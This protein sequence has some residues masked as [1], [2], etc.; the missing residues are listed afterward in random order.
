MNVELK[1][2]H[3]DRMVADQ[4][5]IFRRLRLQ[6]FRNSS[7]LVWD[8]SRIRVI[9][10][11]LCSLVVWASIFAGAMF[12]FRLIAD[13]Q[14]FFAGGIVQLLFETLFFTLGFM[15]FF[16]TGLVIYASLFT[17]SETKF[18]LTT[19][20]R[21]DHIFAMKFQSGILFSSWAFLVLG[22][23][24]LISYG[25]VFSVPWYFYALLPAFFFGYVLIPGA[26]GGIFSLIFV[27][28]FPQ[29]RKTVLV[30]SGVL[31]VGL[32]L[33]WIGR[34]LMTAKANSMKNDSLQ[35]LFD[36]FTLA[37]S[38]FSPSHW[39]ASGIILMA[40]GEATAALYPLALIWANGLFLFL[41]AAYMA[42]KLY[43]R[44][45]NLLAT[46]GDLRKRYGTHFLDRWVHR[47][48]FFLD[49]Q[50]RLLIVKDFRTFRREPA[51]I[52]QLAIFVILLMICIVN[53]RSFF[54]ADIPRGYQF[55]LSLMLIV[56]TLLLITAFLGRFVYPLMSLEGKKFWI[57]GLLP[58]DRKKLL[59]GKFYFA[60]LGTGLFGI[61]LT[62]ISDLVLKM[63]WNAI[64]IHLLSMLAIVSGLC[65]ISVGISATLP[66]FRETD[67]S[68]IVLG[69]GGTMNMIAGLVFLLS[70]V[71]LMLV[72]FHFKAAW[73]PVELTPSVHIGAYLGILT[74]LVVAGFATWMPMR[75]GIRHL[76]RME[77]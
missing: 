66:N 1:L 77:F 38:S 76:D 48:A 20:A 21:A 9:T 33:L 18:L 22:G 56:A 11:I 75:S 72:P 43:R 62:I 71:G 74:G 39:I 35:D 34:L 15:L 3:S 27:N 8:N 37:S 28:V 68:R 24:I 53:T 67:P 65:G 2:D 40:R 64:W 7:N 69:F 12:V 54:R 47:L 30:I 5:Q 41:V 61:G 25:V 6:Q 59:W 29:R 4:G 14:I 46:G 70:V 57:L 51:Q 32:G 60:F 63:P 16:S 58:L 52:G 42:K 55:A 73:T 23:P 26:L 10:A 36:F 45:Y 13:G 17:S 19:P 44:G 50:I 49:P 31:V